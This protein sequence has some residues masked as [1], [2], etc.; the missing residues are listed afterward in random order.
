ML[1][2][3]LHAS[4]IAL[5]RVLGKWSRNPGHQKKLLQQPKA[6]GLLLLYICSVYKPVLKCHYIRFCYFIVSSGF[7]SKLASFF[8]LKFK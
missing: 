6:L 8:L 5:G 1:V 3:W 2:T 7:P 4:D